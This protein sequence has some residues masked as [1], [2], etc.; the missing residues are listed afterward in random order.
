[1]RKLYALILIGQGD[2]EI[3]L[4]EQNVWDWIQG[5]APVPQETIEE[6]QRYEPIPEDHDWEFKNSSTSQNDK[7]LWANSAL[8]HL[9]DSSQIKEIEYWF[10]SV[11]DMMAMAKKDNLEIADS[12]E[13]AIY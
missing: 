10:D 5:K 2:T 1:M 9:E 7:A 8:G 4:V 12:Y 13:G 3:K 6:A 11:A